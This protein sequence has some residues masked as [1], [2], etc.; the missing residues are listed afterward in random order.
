MISAIYNAKSIEESLRGKSVREIF[1]VVNLAERYQIPQLRPAIKIALAETLVTD[2]TVLELAAETIQYADLF[3]E[4]VHYLLLKYAVLDKIHELEINRCSNCNYK[5]ENCQH[6]KV[7][8]VEG[9]NL[10]N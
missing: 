5:K 10:C 1:Y 3:Q 2:D 4:E 7:V 9:R 8:K 6:G